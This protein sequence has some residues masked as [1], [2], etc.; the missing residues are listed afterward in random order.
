MTNGSPQMKNLVEELD[1]KNFIHDL[2]IFYEKERNTNGIAKGNKNFLCFVPLKVHLYGKENENFLIRK[3][4]FTKFL[5]VK[6]DCRV[7][8]SDADILMMLLQIKDQDTVDSLVEYL[9]KAYL[10]EME[11]FGI[12]V[13]ENKYQVLGIPEIKEEQVLTNLQDIALSFGDLLVLINLVLAKDT[14]STLLWKGKP[15][16]LKHTVSK[17]I[18]LLRF[19]YYKDELAE[20]FLEYI[21]FDISSNIYNNYNT[22]AKRHKRKNIFAD[23]DAFE[24]SGIL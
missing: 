2:D 4:E 15:N 21:G 22:K 12:S 24:I 18:T 13:G 16:F 10:G 23:F 3:E 19:Y 14:A 17:Y 9:K 20:K 5:Y 7:Y 11:T 6:N 1:E 8:F